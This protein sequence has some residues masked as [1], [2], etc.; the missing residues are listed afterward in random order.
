MDK[1]IIFRDYREEDRQALENIVR[2]AW[3]Y[4]KFC[5]PKIAAKLAKVYF[6]SCLTNQTFTK[7]A[8][9]DQIPVGIIMGKNTQKHKC[10]LTLRMKWLV[11][12]LSLCMSREGRRVLNIFSSVN[13]IDKELLTVSRKDYKGEVA[14]FA[15][16]T[17]YRGIGL[18]RRLFQTLIDYMKSQNITEFYLFT[19]TSCNYQFYEHLG[20]VRRGEKEQFIDV[21][22][23]GEN[24]TF[25]I[26][27]YLINQSSS[28]ASSPTTR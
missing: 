12:L 3:K 27:E 2:E 15:V 6:N 18:G 10:P 19:D 9:A 23:E 1:Q 16:D 21:N 25:F 7:V 28:S 17:K 26:Y 11:S 5:S 20:L 24:M 13:G 8:V 22:E 14:F 4:E